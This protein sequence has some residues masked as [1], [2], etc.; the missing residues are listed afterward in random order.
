MQLHLDAQELGTQFHSTEA[1]RAY[2]RLSR[3][4]VASAEDVGKFLEKYGEVEAPATVIP[5]AGAGDIRGEV[6]DGNGN[7]YSY[8]LDEYSSSINRILKRDPISQEPQKEPRQ[9]MP[10]WVLGRLAQAPAFDPGAL[11]NEINARTQRLIGLA[12]LYESGAIDADELERR[13]S[14]LVKELALLQATLAAGGPGRL[15]G[16]DRRNLEDWL[17]KQLHKGKGD[18]GKPYGIQHLVNDLR[19]GMSIAQ[20]RNRLRKYARNS[21]QA[22]WTVFQNHAGP[23]GLRVMDPR[24]QHCQCCINEARKGVQFISQIR[25]IG[26]CDCLDGCRCTILPLTL[27]QAVRRG[28]KV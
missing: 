16:R 4:A 7:R 21:R 9:E 15:T 17:A 8:Q 22:F 24:A 12:D 13:A 23:Y 5:Q 2:K 28:V 20:L 27:E 19:K 25:M 1:S 18:N 10:V 6:I 11:R 14:A 3:Q 26:D